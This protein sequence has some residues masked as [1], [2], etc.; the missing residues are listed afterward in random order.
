MLRCLLNRPGSPPGV[1]PKI[2]NPEFD[3]YTKFRTLPKSEDHAAILK[4]GIEGVRIF[5]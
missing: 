3:T 1:E 4:I 5:V 2:I